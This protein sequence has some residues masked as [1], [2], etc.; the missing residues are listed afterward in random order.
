MHA[1]NEVGSVQPIADISHIA[2]KHGIVMHTDDAQS[3]GKIPT[4]VP[5]PRGRPVVGGRA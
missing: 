4:D 1:N 3:V 2:R 5:N